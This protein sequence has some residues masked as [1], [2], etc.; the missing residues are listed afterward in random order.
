MNWN[1]ELY[2]VSIELLAVCIYAFYLYYLCTCLI[3]SFLFPCISISIYCVQFFV[4]FTPIHQRLDMITTRFHNSPGTH[5][6][7]ICC[8]RLAR[9]LRH[10]RSL[11]SGMTGQ[12]AGAP[13]RYRGVECRGGPRRTPLPVCEWWW[14]S[15]RRDSPVEAFASG[16]SRRK[17]WSSLV[18]L[19]D[20]H[21]SPT[22]PVAKGTPPWGTYPTA[23]DQRILSRSGSSATF[24]PTQPR[25]CSTIQ[26]MSASWREHSNFAHRFLK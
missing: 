1:D 22:L 2:F 4:A 20:L 17:V 16:T 23:T 26:D 24:A 21:L 10:R 7:V 11:R 13:A 15:F 3:S 19:E 18:A 5:S 6:K 25:K 8:C 14:P 9:S 12:A